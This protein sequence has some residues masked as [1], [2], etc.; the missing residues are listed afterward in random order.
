MT[1]LIIFIYFLIN[2]NVKK[3]KRQKFNQYPSHNIKF[4]LHTSF[5]F[6]LSIR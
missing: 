2:V 5:V 3:V 6:L 4:G 1:V